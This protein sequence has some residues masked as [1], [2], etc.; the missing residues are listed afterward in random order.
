MPIVSVSGPFLDVEQKR[1]LVL[2]LTKV[3]SEIY[4]RPREYIIVVIREN[5][6][7]NVAVAGKLM[8]DRRRESS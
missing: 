8:L 5:R 7:E 1:E 4:D 6:P 3:A 2:G